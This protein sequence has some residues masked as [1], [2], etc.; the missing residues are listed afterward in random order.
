MNKP[1]IMNNE[2]L[3]A[4]LEKLKVVITLLQDCYTESNEKSISNIV[5][6][7]DLEIESFC[8]KLGLDYQEEMKGYY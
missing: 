6:S 1:I 7:V 3:E 8:C 5:D 2:E 4:Q